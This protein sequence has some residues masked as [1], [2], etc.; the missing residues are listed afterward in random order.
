MLVNKGD[1][2]SRQNPQGEKLAAWSKH[3]NNNKW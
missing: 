2:R 1:L 3:N